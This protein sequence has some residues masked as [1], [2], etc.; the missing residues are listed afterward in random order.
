[1]ERRIEG[2]RKSAVLRK[3]L[4]M[5]GPEMEARWNAAALAHLDEI[6]SRA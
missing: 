2:L 1:M 6:P 5:P 4:E 3:K